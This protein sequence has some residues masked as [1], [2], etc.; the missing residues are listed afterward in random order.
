MEAE[1]VAHSLA[2]QQA[3][4]L[5]NRMR[6][7]YSQLRRSAYDTGS[8]TSPIDDLGGVRIKPP[9]TPV[10]HN[11]ARS[12]TREVTLLE[13]GMIVEHVDV[14]KEEKEAKEKRRKEEK[15]ARKSSRG[16]HL[17][18]GS[19]ISQSS[20]QLVDA[21]LKPST[22]F[23]QAY[24]LRPASVFSP[25]DRPDIPRAYSQI[26]FSDAQS[27]GS[28]SPRRRF[29]G[30]KNLSTGWRSQ[31][32]L[33]PSGMSGSMIDMQYALFSILVFPTRYNSHV[34]SL[35]LQGD[36][37]RGTRPSRPIDPNASS[38]SQ[39]WPPVDLGDSQTSQ[40]RIQEEKPKKKVGGLAKI[41]RKVTGKTDGQEKDMSPTPGPQ[42][43]DPL[44]PPPP[45]S[46]L[47]DRKSQNDFNSNR[48]GSTSSLPSSVASPKFL[49][50]QLTPGMSPPTAPSSIL[51]SPASLRHSGDIEIADGRQTIY[52]EGPLQDDSSRQE[53]PL[54]KFQ[55]INW[56]SMQ[57]LA[58]ETDSRQNMRNSGGVPSPL[59]EN[60]DTNNN[61]TLRAQTI[62]LSR[63]KSLPPIPVGEPPAHVSPS[64]RPKT[65]YGLDSTPKLGSHD[66]APPEAPFR[67]IDM[68]RQSFGGT[69]SRP[70]LA[71]QT[72]PVTKAVDF[73]SKRSFGPRYDEFGRSLGRL[74]HIQ[75]NPSIPPLS[76][77]TT[78]RKSK[79]VLSS[80][81]GKKDRRE[82]EFDS[83]QLYPSLPYSPY[84]NQD[85]TT[86][87]YATSISR[88]SAPTT[89][90]TNMR[91]SVYGRKPLEE[92]VQQDPEFIA[93][94]YPSSDQ[95]LDLLR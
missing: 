57:P 71:L 65:Y 19:I 73:D 70:N 4:Q 15:R 25:S 42:D 84:D 93:Y 23:S 47:V 77:T 49:Q 87:N 61:G 2:M 69:S 59:I 9:I 39:I 53:E 48:R 26:S 31:D 52:S 27:L 3:K 29:F 40:V 51:P 45:L 72:M 89:N 81:L 58:S 41:W 62:S 43:D 44:A 38:R 78:R 28:A 6:D 95:R 55:G 56:Q 76:N 46:Y 5:D 21:G 36:N 34:S 13:N 22:R 67:N 92:L 14:R 85:D 50:G 88:H 60:G 94:R 74:D 90:T 86:T 91:M 82:P 11:R 20:G 64:D 30:A 1:A 7:A 10:S 18:V 75:E 12:H 8:A 54:G 80:L 17:E 16:S 63:E 24:S 35:V 68:R 83:T 33:T 32:S 37:Y 79:F 66:L